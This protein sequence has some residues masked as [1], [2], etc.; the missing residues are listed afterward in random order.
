MISGAMTLDLPIV[1][2]LAGGRSD[3]MGADKAELLLGGVRM[4]DRIV[5]RMA[6]QAGFLFLSGDSDRETGFD[7]VKDDPNGPRGPVAGVWSAHRWIRAHLPGAPGF[8][9]VP[10]DGPFA[11]A[12]MIARLASGNRCAI[13]CD[14]SGDHPTFAYWDM[15]ALSAGFTAMTAENSAALHRLAAHC[16]A[17]RV[18]FAPPALF[19]INTPD[20]LSVAE[21]LYAEAGAD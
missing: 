4:I 3:R 15:E 19:N 20:D 17:R 12:D 6:P 5:E 18:A 2:I 21:R 7:A 1:C 11:P 16:N 10:V 14:D 8:C 13:A 9:T